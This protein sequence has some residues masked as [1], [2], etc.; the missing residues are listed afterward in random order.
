MST[1]TAILSPASPQ[2]KAIL[3][4]ATAATIALFL[5]VG[6]SG[7]LMFF[8]VAPGPIKLAHE[9][10]SLLFV[11]AAVI[12]VVRNGKAFNKLL[13]ARPTWLLLGGALVGAALFFLAPSREGGGNPMRGLAASAQKAPI[14][15]L[16][17]VI[18]A[19]PDE[20]LR[21]LRAQGIQADDAK[22]SANEIAE[23]QGMDPQ[24]VLGAMLTKGKR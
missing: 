11:A 22:L 20:V 3:R 21:R 10:L 5:I 6:V 7:V 2:Q 8:H 13:R 24:R 17:P 23:R 12:H 14:T 19:S 18:G 9:W 16:A 1:N 4:Y 15:A